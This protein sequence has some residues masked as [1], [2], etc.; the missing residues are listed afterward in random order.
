[1][2]QLSEHFTLE[3]L[4]FSQVASRQGIDNTPS[5]AV[6]ANLTRLANTLLE[7]AREIIEA[8]AHVDSGYRSS[9]VNAAVGGAADSA[10]MDGRA[11]DTVFLGVPLQE[12]FDKLRASDLPFDQIIFECQ[13]WIH[14]SVAPEGQEPRRQALTATGHPGAWHYQLVT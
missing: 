6:V 4:T 9:A 7:P 10:H 11:A 13:A 8:P 14:M 5:D 3:E 1:M 12:C 2:T